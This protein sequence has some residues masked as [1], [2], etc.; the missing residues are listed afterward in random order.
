MIH[1]HNKRIILSG[2][3]CS[4]MWFT[5]CK[6][7]ANLTT[8]KK[9]FD[10]KEYATALN[11]Y[12]G[13]YNQTDNKDEKTEAAEKIAESYVYLDDP[14]SAEIWFKRVMA[15][16]PS[17]ADAKLG[18]ARALKANEKY[19]EAIAEYQAYQK[20][21]GT[22]EVVEK[23]IAGCEKA[24]KW[25]REKTR[26]VVI[27]EK[28]LNTDYAEYAPAY[29]KKGTLYF[30]SDRVGD[31]NGDVYEYTGKMYSDIYT[32]TYRRNSKNNEVKYEKVAGLKG[33]NSKYNDGVNTYDTKANVMIYTI[34]NDKN[35][36]GLTCKLYTSSF[37]GTSWTESEV[38][39]FCSDSFNT[40]QPSLSK[41]GSTLYFSSDRPG[42]FGG[43]DLYTVSFNK[44]TKTWGEPVNMGE[45]FNTQMDETFPFIHND[46][47][48]YFSSNGFTGMGRLD[49]Y[50]SKKVNGTWSTP[51]NMKAPINS[52][53]DDFAIILDDSRENGYFSSNREGGKGK[54]DIYRFYMTPL[55][56]SLSGVV[57]DKNTNEP[58]ANSAIA[59]FSGKDSSKIT[60]KT[61]DKGYYKTTLTSNSD[62]AFI[63]SKPEDY[64]LDSK[65]DTLTTKGY[66][67]SED[68]T[69][70]FYLEP[71]K[72]EDEFTLEGIY[73]DVDKADLR[74]SSKLIL[75]TLITVLT[76]YPKIK[77][78]IGSHTDCRS[79]S[80]YNQQ[81][82]AR[83]AESVVNYLI[84]KKIAKARLEAKGYGETRLVNDCACE[85][86]VVSRTCTEEEHQKNRRTTF[87]ILSKNYLKN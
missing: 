67:A 68:F 54:D 63:A 41:D 72:I 59:I 23:E 13:A 52:G 61:D 60:V 46:G 51:V 39:P 86:T 33:I 49:I 76:K 24:A 32:T 1:L 6:S 62:Y 65:E 47:Y 84:E 48:L 85:G 7:K 16:N 18:Y 5:F 29:G 43:K 40:G 12:R 74:E 56:F 15:A 80:A 31:L 42:G 21:F 17:N 4:M 71:L 11:L 2:I 22:N 81:L 57:R 69:K 14:K 70:D 73:Y 75:D 58:I 79:D 3:F 64:Y 10:N 26:Y 37:D 82:S 19:P 45:N 77:I 20:Q 83:R 34:C 50:V 28:S 78:E 44:K 27:N 38:L 25:K 53:G 8:A 87:K 66:E 36:K 9:A 35:G 30:T 55:Q